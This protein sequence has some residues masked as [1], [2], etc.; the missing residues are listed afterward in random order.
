MMHILKVFLLWITALFGM[1]NNNRYYNSS[2]KLTSYTYMKSARYTNFESPTNKHIVFTGG[3]FCN[4]GNVTLNNIELHIRIYNRT[5]VLLINKCTKFPKLLESE[6][7]KYNYTMHV[8][9][10]SPLYTLTRVCGRR[11]ITIEQ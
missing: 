7:K 10:F 11:S 9:T 3:Q 2:I 8:K 5:G 4:T 6:C 1:L